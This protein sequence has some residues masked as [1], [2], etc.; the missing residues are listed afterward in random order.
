MPAWDNRHVF[1][2]SV[3]EWRLA[4]PTDALKTGEASCLGSNLSFDARGRLHRYASELCRGTG[5]YPSSTAPVYAGERPTG[6]RASPSRAL[7][8]HNLASP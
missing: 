3:G 1:G 4:E 2:L 6:L 8:V 5:Q 7:Y